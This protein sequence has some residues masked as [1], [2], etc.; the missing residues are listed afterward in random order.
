MKRSFMVLIS[1]TV[2]MTLILSACAATP[3]AVPTTAPVVAATAV[4]TVALTATALPKIRVATDATFKP[5]E[6]TDDSG[7]MIGI[8]IELMTKIAEKIGVQVEWSNLP[9]DSA[10]AGM[11][12]CQY[13][14]AIAAIYIT[15]LRK[16]SMLFSDPYANAGLIVTVNKKNTTVTSLADLKGLTVAAQLGTSGEEEAKKIENVTYKPYDS[17]ELAFLDLANGQIDAVIADTPVALGYVKANSGSFSGSRLHRDAKKSNAA[18][19]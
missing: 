1:A 6:F 15:D 4:P 18:K 12:E 8:D 19:A 11:T 17:Y 3:T 5:F 9:F 7:N 14:A 16:Q 10:M 13:D 2:L